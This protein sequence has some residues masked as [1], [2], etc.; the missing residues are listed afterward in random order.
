VIEPTTAG[1]TSLDVEISDE[2]LCALALAADPDAPLDPG[3][4]AWIPPGAWGTEL[5]PSWY[6]P[7][8]RSRRSGSW[9]VSIVGLIVVG[10]LLI[11]AFGLCVTSGF[12]S[13]A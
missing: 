12:L 13:W 7:T 4:V 3:A 10:F 6:M 2:E 11:D 5:L 9:P 1:L 8:P